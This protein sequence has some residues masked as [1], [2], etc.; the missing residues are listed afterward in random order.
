MMTFFTPKAN[1]I[2]GL[3]CISLLNS[4][5]DPDPRHIPQKIQSIVGEKHIF[6]FYYNT[7]SKQGPPEFIFAALLDKLDTTK[8]ISDKASSNNYDTSNTTSF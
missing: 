4:L 1:D 7:S 3:D 8:Q 5:K 2:V 6:Q